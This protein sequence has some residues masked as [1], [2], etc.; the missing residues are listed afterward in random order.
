MFYLL[1]Y[2]ALIFQANFDLKYIISLVNVV[3]FYVNYL[4][5]LNFKY[6]KLTK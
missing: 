2:F 4:F 6:N 3:L 1:K 5:F